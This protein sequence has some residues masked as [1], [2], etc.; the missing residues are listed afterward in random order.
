M[1]DGA[2]VGI[3][4][5]GQNLKDAFTGM[6]VAS[7][8]MDWRLPHEEGGSGGEHMF[9]G[10]AMMEPAVV[11]PK[12]PGGDGEAPEELEPEPEPEPI[13]QHE[14]PI[15]SPVRSEFSDAANLS[16]PEIDAPTLGEPS[17]RKSE[18]LRPGSGIGSAEAKRLRA[19]A[20]T[21]QNQRDDMQQKAKQLEKQRDEIRTRAKQLEEQRDD[22][23][24]K[25]DDAQGNIVR[26]R[27]RADCAE[28]E[29]DSERRLR[30]GM[31]ERLQLMERD[32]AR[33]TQAQLPVAAPKQ[34]PAASGVV[35]SDDQPGTLAN[36]ALALSTNAQTIHHLVKG[37]RLAP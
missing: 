18:A 36:L 22:L 14:E 17:P 27:L 35:A 19:R 26:E 5:D 12:A 1:L 3:S 8:S 13:A 30:E 37:G 4:K 25:V 24:R 7:F 31:S 2:K 28:Q 32:A 33:P 16:V 10:M 23:Q 20:E 15:Q 11:D 34:S 9:I 6:A 21:L 29:L